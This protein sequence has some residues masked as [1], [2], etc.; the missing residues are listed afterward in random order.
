MKLN[1]TPTI[2]RRESFGVARRKTKMIQNSDTCEFFRSLLFRFTLFLL[3]DEPKQKEQKK[4]E[5]KMYKY[6]QNQL[7]S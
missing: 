6:M 4:K 1:A 7:S 2:R 3:F 5:T